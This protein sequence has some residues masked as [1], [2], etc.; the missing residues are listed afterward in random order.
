MKPNLAS[1]KSEKEKAEMALKSVVKKI[2]INSMMAINT[3][4]IENLGSFTKKL[5]SV[6]CP[7]FI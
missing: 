6:R 5:R 3:M 4:R 2:V 1:F 7:P